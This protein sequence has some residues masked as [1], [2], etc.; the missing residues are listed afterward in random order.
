[1]LELVSGCVIVVLG[2]RGK[3]EGISEVRNQQST[4]VGQTGIT[5][6]MW[7]SHHRGREG[8]FCL[9][10]RDLRLVLVGWWALVEEDGDLC[11]F[12]FCR[13]AAGRALC[14]RRG[15][16]SSR[17]TRRCFF[18]DWGFSFLGFWDMEDS[19]GFQLSFYSRKMAIGQYRGNESDQAL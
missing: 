6:L 7:F 18:N 1:M 12:F 15:D 3:R 10:G 14:P 4:N 5:V 17:I 11:I 8:Y 2:G 9:G 16:A 19:G 13:G